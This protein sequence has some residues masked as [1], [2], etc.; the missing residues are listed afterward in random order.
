MNMAKE[1]KGVSPVISTVLLI[2][3]VIILAIIILLW[4][5]SFVQEAVTKTIDSRE[6]QIEQWCQEIKL[7]PEISDDGLSFGFT[8][9]GNVPLYKYEL[10]LT[11][12]GSGD[13]KKVL[14]DSA[15]G[16]SVNPGFDSIIDTATNTE[17][18]GSYEDYESIKVIPI[19]LGDGKGSKN[20]GKQEVR[21][22]EKLAITIK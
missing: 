5:N 20:T 12:K 19:L 14:I 10:K 16:G 17:V 18:T 1:K 22:P 21:C 4:A 2:M 11:E 9:T 8:N 3:I 15:K 13:S 6:K 7:T